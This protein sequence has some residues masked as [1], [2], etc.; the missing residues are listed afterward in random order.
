MKPYIITALLLS[1]GMALYAQ[2]TP[3]A[4]RDFEKKLRDLHD[5]NR[6][7]RADGRIYR[8]PNKLDTAALDRYKRFREAQRLNQGGLVLS[9]FS[10]QTDKGKVYNLSPDNMPCL[11]PDSRKV[12]VMPNGFKGVIPDEKMNAIPKVQIIPVKP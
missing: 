6:L 4:D 12:A 10:H 2:Q 9:T 8:M 5:M 1:A 11:V 3:R 7:P